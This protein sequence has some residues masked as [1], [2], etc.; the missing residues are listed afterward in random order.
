MPTSIR[1][2][3]VLVLMLIV[4]FAPMGCTLFKRVPMQVPPNFKPLTNPATRLDQ[5]KQLFPPLPILKTGAGDIS[6]SGGLS[7]KQS[8]RFIYLA[9]DPENLRLNTKIQTEPVFDV[10]VHDGRMVVVFYP[11]KDFPG[12]VFEGQLGNGPS[13]FGKLFGVE[14]GDLLPIFKIGQLVA[15]GSFN[16][17][18]SDQRVLIPTEIADQIGLQKIELDKQTGLPRRAVW[19]RP[20]AHHWWSLRRSVTWDV[21]YLSWDTFKD[22]RLPDE[23]ARLMP[24]TFNIVSNRPHI[25]LGVKLHNS[26]DSDPPQPGYRFSTTLPPTVFNTD[27]N[28]P[29]YPL[30][31]LEEFLKQ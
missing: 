16:A 9:V 20:V 11:L 30:D 28:Y 23:P 5:Y 24:R 12:A 7:G 29:N 22:D 2:V 26:P 27:F 13:P 25:T 8:L 17:K 15:T 14:P 18:G 4:L 31:R 21:T 3:S 10:I 6:A 1:R 19:R